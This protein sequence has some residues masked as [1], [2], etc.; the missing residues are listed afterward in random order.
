MTSLELL[1]QRFVALK[2]ANDMRLGELKAL[3]REGKTAEQALNEAESL[4]DVLD[5]AV[6]VLN[7]VSESR[8]REAQDA[9]E[10]LVTRGLRTIFE[11]DLSFHIES[12]VKGKAV[13]S[14]FVIR[15]T[16][17]NGD[18]VDTPVLDAR[19]GGLAATVGVLLRI[20]LILLDPSQP[21]LLVLD[22]SFAHV[23]R[24]YQGPLA[25]FL[26]DLVQQTGI[27]IILVTHSDQFTEVADTVYRFS[28]V[29]GRT[30]ATRE[31]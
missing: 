20:V 30:V 29:D 23:S 5:R 6:G 17:A 14:S 19:G 13:N 9:I 21:R 11:Q 10:S 4:K 16:L 31:R 7:S 12:S 24:E 8:A 22:E 1:R 25:E 2:S 27:Q 26:A 18:K 3:A 28:Q 15:T